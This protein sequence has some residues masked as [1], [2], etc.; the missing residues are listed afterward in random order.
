MDE[1][2]TDNRMQFFE[3]FLH[4]YD[5]R[6]SFPEHYVFSD[7]ATSKLTDSFK[8]HNYVYLSRGHRK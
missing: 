1:D 3:R 7:K 4:R 8:Q 6:E 2:N 5:E